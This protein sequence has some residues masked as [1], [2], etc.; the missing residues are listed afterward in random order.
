MAGIDILAIILI[1]AFILA[2]ILLL[3]AMIRVGTRGTLGWITTVVGALIGLLL[4]V[5]LIANITNIVPADW[6]QILILLGLV[7]VTGMYALSTRKQADASM[8]MAEEMRNARSPSITMQWGSADP[9]NRKISANLQNEGSGPALNLK[10]YLTHKG[11]VFNYKF[12]GYT[13]FKVG[14]KYSLSLPSEN[15]DFKAWNGLAINCDYESVLGQKFCS[16]LRCESQENRSLE[17][18]RLNSGDKE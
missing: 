11:L 1:I 9:N 17:I 18:K 2:Y 15:F 3:Y 5:Y 4:I 8:K 16:V 6:A 10:C 13:T 14:Q 12:G 7:A